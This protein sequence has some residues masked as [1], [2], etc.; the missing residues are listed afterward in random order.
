MGLAALSGCSSSSSQGASASTHGTATGTPIYVE[1]ED[2]YPAGGQP[3]QPEIEAS[4]QAEFDAVNAAGGIDG[5]P[6]KLITCLD[7]ADP[8]Q[9]RTC[10]N[11]A[12]GNA[13]IVA[14]LDDNSNEYQIVNPIMEAAHLAQ[15]GPYVHGTEVLQC[16]VCFPISG[17]GVV[18]TAAMGLMLHTIYHANSLDLAIPSVPDAQV[19]LNQNKQLFLSLVPKGKVGEQVFPLTVA[20]YSPYVA[21]AKGYDGTELLAGGPVVISWLNTAKSEGVTSHYSMLAVATTPQVLSQGGSLLNGVLVPT[22]TRLP[23]S[24]VPG[25]KLYRSEVQK[26]AP[27]TLIDQG[28][29][30]GWMAAKMFTDV[31]KTIKGPITRA[32]VLNAMRHITNYT[33]LGGLIPPYSTTTKFTGFGGQ[34]PYLFDPYAFPV[35]IENG[36][37]VEIGNTFINP[38]NGQ[39]LSS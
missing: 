24:N 10:A 29:L 20:D 1:H 16:S 4:I 30:Y 28:A 15:I 22:D 14:T 36:K 33:G 27:G 2:G 21:A 37:L 38:F 6:V 39:T 23:T 5:H 34:A 26:Y 31:A 19:A 11:Q 12:V 13:K 35:K 7:H 8:N 25:A 3:A 18:D 17:G 9:A 32:S